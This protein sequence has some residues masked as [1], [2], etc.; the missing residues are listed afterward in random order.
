MRQTNRALLGLCLAILINPVAAAA[1]SDDGG[2]DGGFAGGYGIGEG[3]GYNGGYGYGDSLG[4]G[5]NDC[6]PVPGGDRPAARVLRTEG[7]R[8]EHVLIGPQVQADA[9][10]TAI[11]SV[12]GT[13]IRSSALGGLGQIVQVATFP[14]VPAFERAQ[15][16]VA[17]RAAQTSLSLHHLYGFAQARRSPRLIRSPTS[18]GGLNS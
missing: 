18:S 17:E 16:L 8:Y 1:Q 14:G 5:C 15:A 11:E 7:A 3:G 12:G 9:A 6:E 4:M 13:V 2:Y 10:R